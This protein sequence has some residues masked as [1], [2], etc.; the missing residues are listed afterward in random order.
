[1]GK[2]QYYETGFDRAEQ[3]QKEREQRKN[4]NNRFHVYYS[5]KE[6]TSE[7]RIF[8]FL[9]GAPFEPFL[10]NEH[11]PEINGE[12]KGTES[13]CSRGQKGGCRFCEEGFKSKHIG[14]F[15]VVDIT[16]WRRKG[17]A[18]WNYT[19][20]VKGFPANDEAMTILK[21][22]RDKKGIPKKLSS[23]MKR[24]NKTKRLTGAIF[25]VT[26]SQQMSPRVGSHFDLLGYLTEDEFY[27]PIVFE[28]DDEE[29][30]V[31]LE[32]KDGEAIDLLPFGLS[33]KGKWDWYWEKYKPMSREA[34]DELFETHTVED[35]MVYKESSGSK[36]GKKKSKRGGSKKIPY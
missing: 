11:H 28:Y 16:P 33:R 34:Q 2:E 3:L 27:E 17:E 8:I 7:E 21:R 30:E 13:T 14:L 6:K 26:R 31:M 1:M 20:K 9:D 5:A 23:K 4:A 15:T 24:K 25:S 18:D 35:N 12:W 36:K 19:P 32:N 22:L 29:H 10:I